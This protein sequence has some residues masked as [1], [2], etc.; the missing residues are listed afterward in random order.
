MKNDQN[1]LIAMIAAAVVFLIVLAVAFFTKRD[2]ITPPPAP[3]PVL[4]KAN[5]QEGAVKFADGL[6][7][8]QSSGGGGMAAAGGG[9]ARPG[10][11][12]PPAP[13]GAAP[14]G[15]GGPGA[16]SVPGKGGR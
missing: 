4:G 2:P 16:L 13:G 6:S 1:S 9:M 5:F 3:Q 10:G 14:G 15:A 12:T 8:G 11:G 7:D